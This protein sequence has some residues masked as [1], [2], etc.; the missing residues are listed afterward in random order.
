MLIQKQEVVISGF[1]GKFPESNNVKELKDN[2]F[3]SK[4][5]IIDDDRRWKQDHPEIPERTGKVNNIQKFDASFFVVYFEQANSMDSI[6]NMLLKHAYEAFVD[7]GI[8]PNDIHG[9]RTGVFISLCFSES[10]KIWLY[11]KFEILKI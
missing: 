3:N 11:E 5:C 8:N 2:L 10:E 7:V 1:A 4:D 9:T 6:G